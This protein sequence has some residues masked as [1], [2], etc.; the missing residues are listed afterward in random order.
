ML[1]GA[2]RKL[3]GLLP[4][5]IRQQ[6]DR[7]LCHILSSNGTGQNSM[8]LLWCFG[9]VIIAEHPEDFGDLQDCGLKQPVPTANLEKQ[10]KTASGRKLFGSTNGLYKT[11][12]LT[13]LSV[14]WATKG[15]VGVPDA[16]AIEGIRIAVRTLR[17]VDREARECWPTSSTL[18]R[19]IFPKLPAKFARADI[20]PVVQLEALCFYAMIAG[21]NNLPMDVVTQYQSCLTNLEDL[22]DADSLR[23]TLS[24]S[25]PLFAVSERSIICLI[26]LTRRASIARWVIPD[27]AFRDAR[28]MHRRYNFS[29]IHQPHCL[30]GYTICSLVK[31]CSSENEATVSRV[32]ESNPRE[33]LGPGSR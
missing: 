10:W 18:A 25:L 17:F 13:Y 29:L 20:D 27:V 11:I 3:L 31:L 7:E 30:G 9:I 6:F 32:I 26:Q 16:E 23:E 33:G 2:C 1:N 28:R 5:E 21:A 4:A 19:S 22:A 15:D 12:N 24:V 8:L 14:I